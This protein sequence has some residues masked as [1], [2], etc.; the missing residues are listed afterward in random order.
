MGA[1]LNPGFF[2]LTEDAVM[3]QILVN[4][5]AGMFAGGTGGLLYTVIEDAFGDDSQ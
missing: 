4:A 5:T 3:D 2:G 1:G